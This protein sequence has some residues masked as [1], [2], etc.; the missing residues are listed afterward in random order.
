M[1]IWWYGDG[2]DDDD[3][4]DDEED[5][6]DENDDYDY[7]DGDGDGDDDDGD[8]DDDDDGDGDGDDDD[9]DDAGD[10]DGDDDEDDDDDD[11]GD[12]D[13]SWRSCNHA[14]H[15]T[16]DKFVILTSGVPS[17]L[18]PVRAGKYCAAT[19]EVGAEKWWDA[20]EDLPAG[21]FV[22]SLNRSLKFYSKQL[23]IYWLNM[24]G[25]DDLRTSCLI[26]K[27]F[28]NLCKWVAPFCRAFPVAWPPAPRLVM[29][30]IRITFKVCALGPE[31]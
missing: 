7:D 31:V 14:K 8:G 29:K 26:Q 13:V 17:G 6:D 2:A 22:V 18:Q 1:V 5:D 27:Y 30:E 16:F 11:D 23:F 10:G 21:D 24:V 3:D 9:D 15:A 25:F 4:G 28:P 19:T 12:D 20:S